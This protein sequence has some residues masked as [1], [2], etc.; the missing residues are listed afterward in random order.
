ML[1]HIR[2]IHSKCDFNSKCEFNICVSYLI[3]RFDHEIEFE[4]PNETSESVHL[5][6][7]FVYFLSNECTGKTHN[8]EKDGCGKVEIKVAS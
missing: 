8:V 5:E 1:T 3:L 6:G 2:S 7:K 4:L